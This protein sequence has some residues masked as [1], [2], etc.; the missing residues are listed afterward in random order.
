MLVGRCVRRRGAG[1]G[2]SL[3]SPGQVCLVLEEPLGPAVIGDSRRSMDFRSGRRRSRRS[4][5]LHRRRSPAAGKRLDG[6]GQI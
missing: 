1:R 5:S 3:R 2:L 4:F 6:I